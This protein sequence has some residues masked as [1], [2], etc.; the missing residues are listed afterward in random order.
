M[1][2]FKK[3]TLSIVSLSF[4]T[5]MI[6]SSCST[7]KTEKNSLEK[8]KAAGKI[9][10]TTSPDYA[11]YEFIDLRKQGQDSVVGADIELGKYIAK[12][13]GVELVIEQMDFD[14]V[15]TAVGEG[16]ADMAISGLAPK[17]SR[18]TIVDFS[19]PYNASE[20]NNQSIMVR[21]KD[22][23][24]YKT[25][26]DFKGVKIGVQNGSL[27][28]D[29]TVEQIENPKLEY[30]TSLATGVMMLQ[31]GKI[32][33]LAITTTTGSEF[34][35]S[36]PEVTMSGV[37]FDYISIG[38]IIG[39]PKNQK[40]FKEEVDKIVKEAEEKGLY[41]KWVQEGLAIAAELGENK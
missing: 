29:L 24:K 3:I 35:K 8:I 31:S 22:K 32:D 18:A 7:K 38:T 30:I 37:Y 27:Q 33:A 26:N 13:L 17:E 36:Y 20:S 1:K 23:E 9:V 34:S 15:V 14:S 21:V 2:T 40:E 10:M 12:K 39:L 6:V 4:I 28:Y 19:I 11:P 5:L 25:L 16:K 41:Q